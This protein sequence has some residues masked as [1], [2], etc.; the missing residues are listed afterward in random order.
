[1]SLSFAI[2]CLH[3]RPDTDTVCRLPVLIQIKLECPDP[4]ADRIKAMSG[5]PGQLGEDQ[6]TIS[7]LHDRRDR[8]G[9][10]GYYMLGDVRSRKD[11]EAMLQWSATPDRG[12]RGDLPVITDNR[13]LSPIL[14]ILQKSTLKDGA[15][16]WN[17]HSSV[18]CCAHMIRSALQAG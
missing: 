17:M 1:M 13:S 4:F 18:A 10:N 5:L 6:T 8:A 7:G 3:E 12:R 15:T 14:H 11:I 2:I 9:A 16:L